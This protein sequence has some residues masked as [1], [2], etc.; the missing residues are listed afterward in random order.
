[1]EKI[2]FTNWMPI[3]AKRKKDGKVI[4]AF[5][6]Q[7]MHTSHLVWDTEH[8]YLIT[9]EDEIMLPSPEEIAELK[10]RQQKKLENIFK[11]Y[12]PKTKSESKIKFKVEDVVV[13]PN[14]I[15]EKEV[16]ENVIMNDF[17]LLTANVETI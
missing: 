4:I 1:M 7:R 17:E 10:E 6:Q 12:N 3:K 14:P 9:P 2:D 8:Q 16:K 11:G 13:K 5:Y 15:I